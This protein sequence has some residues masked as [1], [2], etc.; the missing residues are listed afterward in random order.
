MPVWPASSNNCDP[1]PLVTVGIANHED[2]GGV[3]DR[4]TR[5]DWLAQPAGQQRAHTIVARP[6]AH[7]HVDDGEATIAIEPRSIGGD[8]V[9]IDERRVTL[10]P[11]RPGERRIEPQRAE[12]RC[13]IK[14]RRVDVVAGT[15]PSD[16]TV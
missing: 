14:R 9:C 10:G 2:I 4:V 6:F 1:V 15:A 13:G 5:V 11:A 8:A 3:G 12:D 7:R 16:A